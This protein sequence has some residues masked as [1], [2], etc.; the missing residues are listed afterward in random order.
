M[1]V[2]SDPDAATGDKGR[3]LDKPTAIIL[4]RLTTSTPETIVAAVEAD[5]LDRSDLERF[6]RQA[7]TGAIDPPP[8]VVAVVRVLNTTLS[9]NSQ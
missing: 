3:T 7:E 5:T 6:C 8:G 1:A 9:R 4:D 2:G